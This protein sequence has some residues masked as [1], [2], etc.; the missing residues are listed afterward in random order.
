M[1]FPELSRSTLFTSF[2]SPPPSC[3][4]FPSPFPSSP[5]S[6]LLSVLGFFLYHL[7]TLTESMHSAETAI[8]QMHHIFTLLKMSKMLAG[9]K[10]TPTLPDMLILLP[11]HI[12]TGVAIGHVNCQWYEILK[13]NYLQEAQLREDFGG[14]CLTNIWSYFLQCKEINEAWS[15]GMLE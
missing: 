7:K 10:R 14:T 3:L 12:A 2:P 1:D 8:S 4:L 5:P 6:F 9:S 15:P 11:Y 13:G